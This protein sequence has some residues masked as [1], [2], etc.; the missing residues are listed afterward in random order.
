MRVG[1]HRSSP[2]A[3]ARCNSSQPAPLPPATFVDV[4]C[5][6]ARESHQVA[7]QR[8]HLPIKRGEGTCLEG[9]PWCTGRTPMHGRYLFIEL[10]GLSRVLSLCEVEVYGAEYDPWVEGGT[11]AEKWLYGPEPAWHTNAC[12]EGAPWCTRVGENV[13]FIPP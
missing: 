2:L 5:A 9:A 4:A 13:Y 11:N 12:V 8:S 1:N 10:A 3:N 6:G 7:A